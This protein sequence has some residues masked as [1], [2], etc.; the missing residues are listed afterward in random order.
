MDIDPDDVFRDDDD[1]EDEFYQVF[2]FIISF[3]L[4]ALCA[5]ID[6]LQNVQEKNAT[7]EELV[8]LVDAS[9]K[10]FSTTCS[11]VICLSSLH[12][13]CIF[14]L[15]CLTAFLLYCNDFYVGFYV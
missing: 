5:T 6:M 7:K 11:S 3:T 15:P 14:V 8:Y 9:P 12:C 1:P 13:F 10:M 4:E 2:C